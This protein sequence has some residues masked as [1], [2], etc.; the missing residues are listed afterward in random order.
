MTITSIVPSETEPR[1]VA[2]MMKSGGGI[3]GVT[4]GD[5]G[6]V[7]VVTVSVVVVVVVVVVGPG[8][9]FGISGKMSIEYPGSG[10]VSEMSNSLVPLATTSIGISSVSFSDA[11]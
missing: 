11:Y 10:L 3:V 5:V 1:M 7:V 4:G 8:S 9:I 6:V 2:C